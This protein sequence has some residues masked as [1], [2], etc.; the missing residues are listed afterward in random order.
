MGAITHIDRAGRVERTGPLASWILRS[1]TVIAILLAATTRALAHDPGLSALD[2]RVNRDQI[3][4]VL[5]LAAA[6]A[7]IAGGDDAIRRLAL[8]SIAITSDGRPLNGNN[9][10]S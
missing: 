8:E 6:D 7:A 3:V 10:V 1:A 2:V 4:A 9:L 5:S